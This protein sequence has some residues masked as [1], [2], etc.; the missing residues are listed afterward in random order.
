MGTTL[1]VEQYIEVEGASLRVRSAGEG[2]AVV[3]VHGWALD[4][5]MWRTQIDLLADRYRVIAF[6]RRGFG[7]SSGVP[8]IQQDVHDVDRLLDW[9][10]ISRA[11][12]VGMSQGARV[13]LRWA[14]KHPRRALCLVLDG[15][16]EEGWSQSIGAREIPIDEYRHRIRD[17]GVDA[18]R[19]TWLEHPFMQLH[20]RSPCAHTL[21]QEIVVRYPALDLLMTEQ[22]EL[23]L[24]DERD[25]QSMSAPTLVLSGEHDS[26]QRQSI[27]VRMAK[28]LPEARLEILRGAGH[29]GALD[30]PNAYMQALRKFFSSQPAMATN[31][32]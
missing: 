27:A 21:L 24:L 22:P 5:E 25:L 18:F 1:S 23:P 10:G 15:P 12:I 3:L 30:D 6:D 11:A 17:Q 29:L 7:R 31:A 14:L 8:G 9:F 16:P 2:P 32:M 4:L 28:A 13:A 20:T 26:R 19:R